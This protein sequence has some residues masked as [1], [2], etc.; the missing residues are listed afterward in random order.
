MSQ[1]VVRKRQGL[2]GT[3]ADAGAG[4]AQSFVVKADGIVYPLTPA[5]KT[6]VQDMQTLLNKYTGRLGFAALTVDG[7][8]GHETANAANQY[9]RWSNARHNTMLPVTTDRMKLATL[10][11]TFS[12]KLRA[13]IPKDFV[14]SVAP[15]AS[16]TAPAPAAKAPE[17]PAVILE[18]APSGATVAIKKSGFTPTVA[19]VGL[20]AAAVLFFV[21]SKKKG[22]L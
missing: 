11:D 19:I 6:K 15:A 8:V 16:K 3:V 9:A 2:A 7:R 5:A 1:Y 13:S 14:S 20:G 22:I 12:A 21:M 10:A 18:T 4:F 17:A